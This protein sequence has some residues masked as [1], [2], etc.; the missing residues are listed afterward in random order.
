MWRKKEEEEEKKE[1]EEEH[2]GVMLETGTASSNEG[3]WGRGGGGTTVRTPVA[4]EEGQCL[5]MV[6]LVR[7]NDCPG[8]RQQ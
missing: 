7:A 2:P 5:V 1:K 3:C 8:T 6:G 4:K